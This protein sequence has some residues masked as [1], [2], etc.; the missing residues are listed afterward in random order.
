MEQI[1]FSALALVVKKHEIKQKKSFLDKIKAAY[2]EKAEKIGKTQLNHN[3]LFLGA[4]AIAF[5]VLLYYLSKISE[6]IDSLH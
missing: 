2:Y 1:D 6:K 5:P 3:L 4:H